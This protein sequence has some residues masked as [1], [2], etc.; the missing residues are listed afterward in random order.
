MKMPLNASRSSCDRDVGRDNAGPF[1]RRLAFFSIT[2]VG[3]IGI[4]SDSG[5]HRK[6]SAEDPTRSCKRS[7][8]CYGIIDLILHKKHLHLQRP[9]IRRDVG[10]SPRIGGKWSNL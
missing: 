5:R 1:A 9:V 2:I 8:R 6:T 10:G 7:S 3:V 4:H